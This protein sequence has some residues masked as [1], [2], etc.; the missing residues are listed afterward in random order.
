MKTNYGYPFKATFTHVHT[1]TKS[2]LVGM[3]WVDT[4][5]FCTWE[6]AFSWADAVN[7]NESRGKCDYRVENLQ[8]EEVSK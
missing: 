4:M 3:S 5:Q 2:A 7:K 8:V 6:D 1:N